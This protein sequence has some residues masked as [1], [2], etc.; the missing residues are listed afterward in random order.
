MNSAAD[1]QRAARGP[2]HRGG[3]SGQH[4]HDRQQNREQRHPEAGP[5]TARSSG[6]Q[7]RRQ[8]AGRGRDSPA[9]QPPERRTH[10]QRR[11][12]ADC[13]RPRDRPA[14]VGVE[15]FD[16]CERP[17]VRRHERVRG[18]QAGHQ[19]QPQQ[20]QRKLLTAGQRE[21]DRREQH[22]A[23][24]EEDRQAH[25]ERDECQDPGHMPRAEQPDQ[26]FGHDLRTTGLRQHLADD[27]SKPDDDRDEPQ[28]VADALLEGAYDGAERHARRGAHEERD[29]GQSNEGVEPRP[30]DEQHE[31]D[32]GDGRPEQQGMIRR[33]HT[34]RARSRATM[35]QRSVALWPWTTTAVP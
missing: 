15:P 18:R 2:D 12:Q 27:G 16:R 23:D 21:H 28:R 32:D 24:A 7:L 30:R 6:A 34:V 31:R 35:R 19:R 1:A 10:Q 22:E 17:G 13:E 8:C 5:A 33:R 20:Q 29:E 3:C 11:R 4:Q 14:H 25:D 9:N 26:P